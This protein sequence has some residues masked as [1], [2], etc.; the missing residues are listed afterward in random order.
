M[1]R[2]H[3]A[4][5]HGHG[6]ALRITLLRI[7]GLRITLGVTL[8]I[9]HRLGIAGWIAHRLGIALRR[10]HAGLHGVARRITDGA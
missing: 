1:W 8:R 10:H 9:A 7:A 2:W 6:I 4:G 3:H 5:L